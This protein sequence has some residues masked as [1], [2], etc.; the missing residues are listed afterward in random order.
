MCPSSFPVG[1]GFFFV[2]RKDR[3]LRPCIDYLGLNAITIKDKY[4][5]P[6]I[7]PAIGPLH[8]ASVFTK[9]DLRNVYHLVRIN[10][11]DEWKTSFNILLVSYLV[12]PL[13]TTNVPAV[14]QTLINDV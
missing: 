13:G 12:M 8:E 4:P 1:A 5:P 2:E 7:D 6:L 11:G 14:F 9:L 3:S 10:E